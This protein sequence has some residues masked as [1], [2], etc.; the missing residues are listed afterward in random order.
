MDEIVGRLPEEEALKFTKP[1]ILDIRVGGEIVVGSPCDWLESTKS[2]VYPRQL[3]F[4][5]F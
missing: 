3:D 2:R 1:A 4:G 5:N